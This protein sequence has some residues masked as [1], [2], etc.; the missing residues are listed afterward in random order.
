MDEYY[1]YA[2]FLLIITDQLIRPLRGPFFMT[3]TIRSFFNAFIY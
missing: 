1:Q 2:N 3:I